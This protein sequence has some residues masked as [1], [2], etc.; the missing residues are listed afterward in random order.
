[1]RVILDETHQATSMR[2]H[3]QHYL[4]PDL[5]L[6]MERALDRGEEMGLGLA[7]TLE[8]M[9]AEWLATHGVPR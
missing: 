5:W 3:L 2:R 9:A 1:M 4:P 7:M 8:A 6:V